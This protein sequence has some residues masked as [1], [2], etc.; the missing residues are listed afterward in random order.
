[1][2]VLSTI[3][4]DM[5]MVHVRHPAGLGQVGNYILLVRQGVLEMRADQRHDTGHLSPQQEPEERR[6]KTP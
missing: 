5:M 3:V 4:V 2:L 6:T 1:M